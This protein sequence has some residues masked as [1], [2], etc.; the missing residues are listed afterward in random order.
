MA[1][2]GSVARGF[3]CVAQF[4]VGATA[5]TRPEA[6]EGTSKLYVVQ[7]VGERTR[8]KEGGR[9]RTRDYERQP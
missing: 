9:G 8:G 3:V 4:Q 1:L 2:R 7:E 5:D 6:G